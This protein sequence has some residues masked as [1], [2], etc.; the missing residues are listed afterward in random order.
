VV[1]IYWYQF[2][3]RLIC[4]EYMFLL[5]MHSNSLNS[6]VPWRQIFLDKGEQRSQNISHLLSQKCKTFF[7]HHFVV[8]DAEI[9]SYRQRSVKKI[10]CLEQQW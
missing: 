3:L 8:C 1:M 7:P 9:I 2:I 6:S 10:L 5:W 4:F